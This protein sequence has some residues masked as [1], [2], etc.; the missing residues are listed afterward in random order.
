MEPNDQRAA[1]LLANPDA[2]AI[3][4]ISD[5]QG[6]TTTKG[7]PIFPKTYIQ[8][9]L[10]EGWDVRKKFYVICDI[11]GKT[12]RVMEGLLFRPPTPPGPPSND[13]IF[14]TNQNILRYAR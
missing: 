2:T 5:E 3:L 1:L 11:A 8:L 13:P 9:D 14:S 10:S 4:Y 12:I 7:F 6:V